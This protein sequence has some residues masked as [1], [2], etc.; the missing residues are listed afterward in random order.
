MSERLIP[1]GSPSPWIPLVR[2]TQIWLLV[3]LLVVLIGSMLRWWNTV[4][5]P[6][7][8]LDNWGMISLGVLQSAWPGCCRPASPCTGGCRRLVGR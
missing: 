7:D 5:G 2:P 8:G 3:S 6:V 1:E 4:A